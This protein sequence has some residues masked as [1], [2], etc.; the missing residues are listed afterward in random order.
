MLKNVKI[1][2]WDLYFGIEVGVVYEFL[3]MIGGVGFFV[4][5]SLF[6]NWGGGEEDVIVDEDWYIFMIIE[7][8]EFLLKFYVEWNV[9]KML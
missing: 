3:I 2:S 9:V 6:Y 4:K 5:M 7:I 1:I 8:K